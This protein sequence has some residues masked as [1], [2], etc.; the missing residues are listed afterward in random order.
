MREEI[1]ARDTHLQVTGV[2]VI[3]K[4]M[5]QDEIGNEWEES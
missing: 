3:F 5:R 4:A 1:Q 2:S